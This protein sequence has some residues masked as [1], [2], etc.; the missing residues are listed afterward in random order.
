MNLGKVELDGIL[1]VDGELRQEKVYD[2]LREYLNVQKAMANVI[3]EW[4]RTEG[5][6]GRARVGPLLPSLA[7]RTLSVAVSEMMSGHAPVP[8]SVDRC[9]VMRSRYVDKTP[10]LVIR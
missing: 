10:I 8:W 1:S 6:E 7:R 4:I 3:G 5:G 9:Q 2:A